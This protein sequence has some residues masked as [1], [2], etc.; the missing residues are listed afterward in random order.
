MATSLI[1]DL[2]RSLTT[3]ALEG[4][5]SA[6]DTAA[7]FEK[8][9]RTFV[10]ETRDIAQDSVLKTKDEAVRFASTSRDKARSFTDDTRDDL[11]SYATDVRDDVEDLA[12]DARKT[13]IDAVSAVRERGVEVTKD[14]LKSVRKGARKIRSGDDSDNES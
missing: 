2:F 4:V 14:A 7:S 3:E 5:S 6:L 12:V 8:D 10:T 13:S 11:A 1:T 9:T